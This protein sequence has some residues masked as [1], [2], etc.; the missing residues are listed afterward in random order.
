MGRKIAYRYRC[1]NKTRCYKRRTLRKPLEMYVREPR[2]LACGGELAPDKYRNTKELAPGR[3]CH[4][5]GLHHP[6]RKGGSV[7]CDHHP[8]GPTDEDFVARYGPGCLEEV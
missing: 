2:C 8:T 1:R 4:C 7:W 5:G 6:H 3:V